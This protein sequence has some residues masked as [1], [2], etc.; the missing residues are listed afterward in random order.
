M[1]TSKL[2]ILFARP[3]SSY[4]LL[5]VLR[6][7][8]S[9]PSATSRPPICKE[10]GT[11]ISAEDPDYDPT[12]ELCD[13]ISALG[14]N[15]NDLMYDT[16][17]TAGFKSEFF[18]SK[19]CGEMKKNASIQGTTPF[20]LPYQL[21]YWQDSL[22]CACISLQ[23][24]L[25]SGMDA[26]KK[27]FVCLSTDQQPLVLISEVNQFLFNGGL[28]FETFLLDDLALS[29]QDKHYLRVIQKHHPKK[30]ARLVAVSKTWG[31]SDTA[32]KFYEQCIKST[33][34]CLH[35]FAKSE[36]GDEFSH[37]KN[38][39]VKLHVELLIKPKYGYC[40]PEDT[41]ALVTMIASA[42]NLPQ[43]LVG[44]GGWEP[45]DLSQVTGLG[46]AR[47]LQGKYD[48]SYAREHI[49]QANQ[50]RSI[51]SSKIPNGAWICF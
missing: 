16:A 10:T 20:R 36:D 26:Y 17:T 1:W 2:F 37:R 23:F 8:S 35:E 42:A 43:S 33:C 39:T 41:V 14:I 15:D 18:L 5:A 31:R 11:Y 49:L 48:P 4:S 24:H 29:D 30:A 38:E 3:F 6:T 21:D 44:G 7:H 27:T 50:R 12:E 51:V 19:K 45:M 46:G 40:P 34:K 28:A 47:V 32:G 13:E 9:F 22:G 25:L